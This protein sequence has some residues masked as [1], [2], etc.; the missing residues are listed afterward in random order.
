MLFNNNALG[1]ISKEQL[2]ADCQV[3]H[4]SLHDPDWA[5]HA[6]LCG[7]TG[8]KATTREQLDEAMASLL[9]APGPALLCVEQDAELL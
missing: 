3:W 2:A 9:A 4:T 8:I 6:E 7:A 1:K 5:A